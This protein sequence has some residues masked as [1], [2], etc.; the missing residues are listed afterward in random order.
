MPLWFLSDE[1]NPG[2]RKRSM[3][4]AVQ[5]FWKTDRQTNKPT[6]NFFNASKM[7]TNCSGQAKF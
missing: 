6:R 2:R 1:K 3:A 4:S 7:E 5:T